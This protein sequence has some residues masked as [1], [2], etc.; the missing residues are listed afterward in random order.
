VRRPFLMFLALCPGLVNP[1]AAGAQVTLRN[2]VLESNRNDYTANINGDRYSSVWGYVHGDGREY[3]AIGTNNGTAI[4]NVTDPANPHQ[5]G[6]ITG[7]T[8][9]WRNI[10]SYRNWIYITTEGTG[11]G[12]GLQVVSMADPENP[13]LTSTYTATFNLAHTMHM[14]TTRALLFVNG[15]RQ[16]ISGNSYGNVPTRILSLANPAAPVYV[17]EWDVGGYPTSYVH[18]SYERGDTLYFASVYAGR[19]RVLDNTNP[20]APVEINSWT[21][22]GAFTHSLWLDPP[23]HILYVADEVNGEPLKV[24]D[25][26]DVMNPVMVN[27]FTSNPQAI[28]HNP[29]VNGDELYLANYTEGVRILDITDPVHPAEFASADSYPGPS[30]SYYGVWEVYPYFPSGTVI[31]SDM[32]TGLYVYTPV[33]NYGI[34]RV[35]VIDADTQL[36]I[37]GVDVHLTTQGDSLVTPADGIVQFGPSPGAHTVEAELFGYSNG[38]AN[39]NV[40]NGSRDTVTFAL[41]QLPLASFNGT[42]VSSG[43]ETPLEDSEVDLAYTLLHDHT[44]VSG[45]FGFASVPDNVYRVEVHSPGYVPGWF[46][47]R[48]GPGYEDPQTIRQAAA[49]I[50]DNLE[51]PSGWT[52]GAPGDEATSGQWVRVEPLGTGN[53]APQPLPLGARPDAEVSPMMRSLEANLRGAEPAHPEPIASYAIGDV[54]P[55]Y[56]RTPGAGQFCYVTGQGTDPTSIGQADVDNGRT[57]LTTPALALAGMS[58]PHI[59]WWQWFFADNDA[60]DWLA[61][62]ISN[63]DGVTW[64]DVDT[65]RGPLTSASWEERSIR[66]A[67][68]VTPTNLVKV[69]FVAA[70]LAGQNVVE[71]AIDDLIAWDATTIAV[72]VAPGAA[73]TRFRF[74]APRPNPAPG[75]VALTLDLPEA[76]KVEVGLYD[77]GGRRVRT[78]HRG[79]APAGPLVLTWDGNDDA[80]RRAPAGL[81]FARARMNGTSAQ[82]RVVRV[83]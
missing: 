9:L 27:A 7:P 47:R 15:P 59:A 20:A 82:T 54:Q 21:Y 33:R 70:D 55:E 10:K 67:D 79:H 32:Q 29:H 40:T 61:V 66:V 52:V 69:R 53:P 63:D 6:Y 8:S 12:E 39:V 72:Y 2:M 41:T 45:A 57:S 78:L 51:A 26:H 77:V 62:R 13:V 19:V 56:D 48:I 11:T 28:I 24:F 76:G 49:P 64:T 5:V 42:V 43:S 81:Y 1:A 50:Y 34:V 36:P 73:G 60:N 80:G 30:G 37:P 71:S 22:P 14:D 38:F 44:T 25:V 18:D 3:A 74:L 35:R 16:F 31:A 75:A 23:S 68:F 4:Y 65:L 58:D 46:N 17:G 83:D